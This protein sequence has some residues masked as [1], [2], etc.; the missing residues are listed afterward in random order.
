MRVQVS[1]VWGYGCGGTSG[2]VLSA[3]LT[4][5]VTSPV[6]IIVSGCVFVCVT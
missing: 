2:S 1:V 6:G 5:Y 3:C 4:P